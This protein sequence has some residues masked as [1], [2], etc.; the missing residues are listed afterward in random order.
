MSGAFSITSLTHN[1][2]IIGEIT[3]EEIYAA[4]ITAVISAF[5]LRQWAFP[6]APDATSAI[7]SASLVSLLYLIVKHVFAMFRRSNT[8]V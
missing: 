7:M 1:I 8:T 5:G 6:T 3:D 4:V 2:P